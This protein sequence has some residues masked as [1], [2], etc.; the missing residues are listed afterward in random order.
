[1]STDKTCVIESANSEQTE[2]LAEHLG[3][4][5]RG[6]EVI[7]LISDLGGGKTTFTRGLARGAGSSDVVA[8][9]TFT[10]SKVYN[11]EHFQIHHFDFYRLGES[12]LAAYELQDLVD[13]PRVVIVVEWGGVVEHVLPTNRV[14]IAIERTGEDGRTIRIGYTE[15]LEYLTEGIC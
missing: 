15:S 12:G 8:S 10:I 6:G 11:A 1:M 9:P 13:D 3:S 2:Q 7:E 14:S 4:R 5:L